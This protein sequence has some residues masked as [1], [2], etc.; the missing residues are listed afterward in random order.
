YLSFLLTAIR[1]AAPRGELAREPHPHLYEAG[2]RAVLRRQR[3]RLDR[4]RLRARDVVAHGLAP[5]S[6]GGHDLRA[7]D[8]AGRVAHPDHERPLE[9][10]ALDPLDAEARP[11]AL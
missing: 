8:P 5:R 2:E 4:A 9:D 11:R 1:H 6:T 3:D 10:V 7:D